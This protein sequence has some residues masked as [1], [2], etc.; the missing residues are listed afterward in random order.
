M[1]NPYIID[2]LKPSSVRLNANLYTGVALYITC[3]KWNFHCKSTLTVSDFKQLISGAHLYII[4]SSPPVMHSRRGML[5]QHTINLRGI[6]YIKLVCTIHDFQ[7]FK[8]RLIVLC[9]YTLTALR[10]FTYHIHP[11]PPEIGSNGLISTL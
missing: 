5:N 9:L 8:Y 6:P 3:H 4:N 10:I 2:G 11:K 7:L 1:R